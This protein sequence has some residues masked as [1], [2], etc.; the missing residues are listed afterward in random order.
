MQTNPNCERVGL[1]WLCFYKLKQEKKNSGRGRK[2]EWGAGGRGGLR[3]SVKQTDSGKG[4]ETL[5]T[6]TFPS[7]RGSTKQPHSVAVQQT[8][9]APGNSST[10]QKPKMRWE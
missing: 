6:S 8:F 4:K 10:T 5:H 7:H 1:L 3:S 2:G 9:H